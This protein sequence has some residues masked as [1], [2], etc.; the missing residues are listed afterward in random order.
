MSFLS[1]IFITSAGAILV[2]I[3]K[4]VRLHGCII[5]AISGRHDLTANSLFH[6]LLTTSLPPPSKWPRVL[7]SGGVLQMYQLGLHSRHSAFWLVC[8]FLK[9]SLSASE[10]AFFQDSLPPQQD[11]HTLGKVKYWLCAQVSWLQRAVCYGE[12][13][14]I[15]KSVWAGWGGREAG[16]LCVLLVLEECGVPGDLMIWGE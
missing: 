7:G 9:W 1:S 13:E 10:V 6:Q 11:S 2:Q 3:M 16:S 14:S 5:S 15:R 8:G 12:S 4:L